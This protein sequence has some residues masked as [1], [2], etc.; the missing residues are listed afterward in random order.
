MLTKEALAAF[1]AG[2]ENYQARLHV[3]AMVESY[4]K[5][6]EGNP[7]LETLLLGRFFRDLAER[8]LTFKMALE[9]L[10]AGPEGVAAR[11][12]ANEVAA[13]A[14]GALLDKTPKDG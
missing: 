3:V 4:Q 10:E 12:R 8:L 6:F 2:R 14:L 1:D 9:G 7:D 5:V 11:E 13:L